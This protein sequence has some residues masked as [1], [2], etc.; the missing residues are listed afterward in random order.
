MIYWH[1]MIILRREL[2]LVQKIKK[3]EKWLESEKRGYDVGDQDPLVER[4]ICDVV[5]NVGDTMRHEAEALLQQVT[6]LKYRLVNH[7][8]PNGENILMI[9]RVFCEED[10]T[11]CGVCSSP[12]IP[13]GLDASTVAEQMSSMSQALTSPILNED[14]FPFADWS[15][16]KNI[17]PGI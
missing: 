4:R 3:D 15:L 13:C 5:K 2:P 10:G 8:K 14:D 9:H 17:L 12:H 11:V 7:K 16:A 1:P 6:I